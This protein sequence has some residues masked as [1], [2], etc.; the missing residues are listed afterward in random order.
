MNTQQMI[1]QA[2]EDGEARE[3][4]DQPEGLVYVGRILS[5]EPIAGAD[6]NYTRSGRPIEGIVVRSADELDPVRGQ[7]V[8]FKVL[9]PKYK[10]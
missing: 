10:H 9:N 6:R 3:A 7:R 5:L 8:S 4:E 2:I 1:A